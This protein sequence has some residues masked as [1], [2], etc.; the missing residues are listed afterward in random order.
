MGKKTSIIENNPYLVYTSEP[1][2]VLPDIG[3]INTAIQ[4]TVTF[5]DDTDSPWIENAMIPD[6]EI[7]ASKL[8]S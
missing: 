3:N 8:A 5:D 1:D 6:G 2:T 4:R 7:A